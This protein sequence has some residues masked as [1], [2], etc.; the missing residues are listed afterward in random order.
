MLWGLSFVIVAFGQ[1]AWV[2]GL[3]IFAGSVGYALF[4]R[5]LQQIDSVSK[6]LL[7][8]GFWF[9]CVQSIQLSWLTTT[10][11]MGGMILVIYAFLLLGLG[12][13][14]ALLCSLIPAKQPLS[15]RNCAAL[16]GGWVL[17][18]WIRVYFLSGFTWNPV[19]LALADS[20]YSLQW[21]A[22][23]GVYGLSFWVILTN[24]LALKAWSQKTKGAL[25]VWT[26]VA[27]FPYG[28]GGVQQAWIDRTLPVQ[29]VLSVALIQTGLY[30]EQKDYVPEKASAYIGPLDQW[31]RAL[32]LF[33]KDRSVD[34]I[35][36][37]ESA[38]PMRTYSFVY[39]LKTVQNL[40]TSHFGP[41][42]TQDFPALQKPYALEIKD[43]GQTKW[44][45]NNAFMA[46]ALANHYRASLIIGLDDFDP[47]HRTRYNAAFLFQEGQKLP[48][49]YEK[50]ALVPVSEYIPLQG[51]EFIGRFLAE[52]YG[53]YDSFDRGKEAKVFQAP[54][55]L[56]ISICVEEVYSHLI[57]ELRQKGAELLVNL[58][59]DIWFPR[60][61]LAKQHY[62]HGRIRAVENGVYL[63][64]SCNTGITGGADCLG[65]PLE[66]FPAIETLAGVH[67][68]QI[69]VRS[70]HTLYT[71]WGNAAILTLSSLSVI[72]LVFCRKKK[73]P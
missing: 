16:A 32:G 35:V 3:G 17:F 52:Q 13:Q 22:V 28:F 70:Y 27:L 66:Q 43:Q 68:L 71:L 39:P 37:P 63:I 65:R 47:I 53:I 24:G 69:P 62:D 18:E 33:Q 67:Y 15:Y 26:L 25:A 19:G 57:R 51:W 60:S 55:P 11:Y 2:P 40:W 29:K 46:Q 7:H 36:F 48:E 9:L 12:A 73:L 42:A 54:V 4:W 61:S 41:A 56:G 50:R 58:S 59:N 8:A 30:P 21:A 38:F 44:V 31:D 45:V 6:R 5:A 34:L 14:F 20:S 23:F 64:R 49:R 10:D 72:S 1:P